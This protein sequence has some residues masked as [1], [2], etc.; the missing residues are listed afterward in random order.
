[1]LADPADLIHM[2]CLMMPVSLLDSGEKVIPYIPAFAPG[3]QPSALL[4]LNPT[5]WR[6]SIILVFM[7]CFLWFLTQGLT[8]C[9]WLTGKGFVRME[10]TES[11]KELRAFYSALKAAGSASSEQ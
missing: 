7:S 5:L 1:M 11:L 10:M 2:L 3:T 4:H 8:A 9:G 6:L